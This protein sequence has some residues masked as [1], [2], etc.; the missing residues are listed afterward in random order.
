MTTLAEYNNNP[1]SI[2]PPEGM[3]SKDK[4]PGLIGIDEKG[5]G[6]FATPEFGQ[7]ALIGDL[8]YKLNKRGIK[9]P[10][11]FVDIYTPAG[12][13]NPED[14]RDNYKIYIARKLGLKSTDAPFPEN[15]VERLAQAVTAFEGGT[16]QNPTKEE[17]K[18]DGEGSPKPNFDAEKIPSSDTTSPE[19]SE[20]KQIS[21]V[22]GGI[23]GGVAGTTVGTSAA[24]AKAKY[25]ALSEAYD[26]I[27]G[28]M[29]KTV[30]DAVDD[31]RRTSVVLHSVWSLSACWHE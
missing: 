13:E 15:V 10:S 6:V 21:P 18:S 16:W 20:E 2:R 4:Y 3:K 17:K 14:A 28:R 8:T 22:V 9:T 1:G 23:V 26:A 12:E 30:G 11:E 7:Q 19:A 27:T 31:W 25:D 24:V 5:F 29:G